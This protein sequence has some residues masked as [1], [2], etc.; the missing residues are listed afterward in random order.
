[1]LKNTA[2]V[3]FKLLYMVLFFG[4]KKSWNNERVGKK[5]QVVIIPINYRKAK[6][7]WFENEDF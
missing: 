6:V 1:M 2:N 7:L 5:A 3:L 4:K